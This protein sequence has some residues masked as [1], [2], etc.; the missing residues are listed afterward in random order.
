MKKCSK[1]RSS[2]FGFTNKDFACNA[3]KRLYN[4]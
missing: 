4:Q 3:C 1:F 2:F